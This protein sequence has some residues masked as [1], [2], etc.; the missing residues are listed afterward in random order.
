[1]LW[2]TDE[3]PDVS[4]TGGSVRQH[5][6]L[7]AVA[8]KVPVTVVVAAARVPAELGRMAADLVVVPPPV[9]PP[10][11]P[12][13]RTW[14]VSLLDP[15]PEDVRNGRP[16]RRALAD[17]VLARLPDHD[18]V[19]VQHAWLAPLAAERRVGQRWILDLHNLPSVRAAH[20]R[21]TATTWRARSWARA[22]VAKGRRAETRMVAAHDLVVVPSSE[23]QRALGDD[24]RVRVVPNGVDVDRY[25]PSPLPAAPRVVFT[26]HLAYGPNVDAVTWFATHVWPRVRATVPEATWD[27]VGRAPAPE[28]QRLDGR[29]G[30]RVHADVP[31]TRPFLDGARVVVVPVRV[32]SGTR[33]KALEAMACGRPVV[34]T[35]VGLEG[36]AVEDGVQV[37]RRDAPEAMA[38]AVVDL[39]ADSGRCHALGAAGRAHVVDRFDWSDVGDR[40]ATLVAA[41]RRPPR[42]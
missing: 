3:V 27:V 30:I 20:R 34:G 4:G 16:G 33:L 15:A 37:L 5:H 12:R 40:F 36:L 24:A 22:E 32:G 29:A 1:M 35:T 42:P 38:A 6:L 28:V 7:R 41:S 21:A 25:Q 18:T 14:T 17:A 8:A 31:S 11:A 10:P 19:V 23:D 39:L 9:P 13:W 2:V 26:G